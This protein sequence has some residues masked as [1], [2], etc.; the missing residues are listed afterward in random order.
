V[1][2]HDISMIWPQLGP[3]LD[4]WISIHLTVFL[5]KF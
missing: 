4:T 5:H 2:S 1:Y 3:I